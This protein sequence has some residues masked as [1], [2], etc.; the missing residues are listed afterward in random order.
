MRLHR[1]PDGSRTT[2]ETLY[3]REWCGV[4]DALSQ[5][6]N[7]EVLGFDPFVRVYRKDNMQSSVDLPMWLV[8]EML[9]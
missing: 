1:L 4:G 2:D 3:A 6:Y 5:K 9:K 8:K 7:L